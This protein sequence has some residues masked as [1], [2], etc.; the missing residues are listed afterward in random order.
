MKQEQFEALQQ[1]AEQLIDVFLAESDPNE[2]PGAGLKPSAMDKSTRGDRYWCKR[3][4]AATLACAQRIG[5]LVDLA[6]RKT[7]DGDDAP[8]AVTDDDDDLQQEAEAAERE[9]ARLIEKLQG[10][11]APPRAKKSATKAH[12][13]QA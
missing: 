13:S 1:R 8:G 5:A 12:G 9:A 3:D 6:R 2:W 4:A 11:K 7:A 10:G